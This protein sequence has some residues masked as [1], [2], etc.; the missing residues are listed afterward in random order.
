[1]AG[2]KYVVMKWKDGWQEVVAV[3]PDAVGFRKYYVIERL[4][5]FGRLVLD[6]PQGETPGL[7]VVD[8]DPMEIEKIALLGSGDERVLVATDT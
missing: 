2:A 5:H 7:I 4:E 8:R 6:R 1:M 3:E